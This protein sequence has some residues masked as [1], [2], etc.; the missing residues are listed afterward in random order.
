MKTLILAVLLAGSFPLIGRGASHDEPLAG[1]AEATPVAK[2]GMPAAEAPE[3]HGPLSLTRSARENRPTFQLPEMVITGQGEA[4]A[5]S[6]RGE[7]RLDDSSAGL[8]SSP[9]EEEGS[10]NESGEA[11]RS[12]DGASYLDRP[13]YGQVSGALGLPGAWA[14][15]LLYGRQEESWNVLAQ[16]RSHG[17]QTAPSGLFSGDGP[18]IQGWQDHGLGGHFGWESSASNRFDLDLEVDSR[19]QALRAPLA[20]SLARGLGR[21]EFSW[22]AVFEGLFRQTL[23]I[24]GAAA[25]LDSRDAAPAFG[26]REDRGTLKGRWES[27]VP[28]LPGRNTLSWGGEATLLGQQSYPGF[29]LTGGGRS[30]LWISGDLGGR[31]SIWPGASLGVAVTGQSWS[32]SS[33]VEASAWGLWPRLQ[34]DQRLNGQWSL[35]AAYEPSL[36]QPLFSGSLY[37]RD[38]GVPNPLL[39]PERE[40]LKASGGVRTHW[41]ETVALELSGFYRESERFRV[42][43]DPAALGVWS[44]TDAGRVRRLGLNFQEDSPLGPAASQFFNYRWQKAENLDTAAQ[45][46]FF[47]EHEARLGVKY[48]SHP[49]LTTASL[50]G[51]SARWARQSGGTSMEPALGLDLRE[52]YQWSEGFTIFAEGLNLLAQP[53]QEWEG[54]PEAR[55]YLGLGAIARF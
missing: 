49:W 14:F 31:F 13:A 6:Q 55:P 51:V 39:L 21:A 52:E 19:E 53:L 44:E 8:K 23:S 2:K 42:W 25:R 20:G 43:D 29:G 17:K 18:T 11:K 32:V 36:A 16:A 1:E 45:V 47:P 33:P 12:L 48:F 30:P 40:F 26:F 38:L 15:D 35:F 9:A 3:E 46:P 50:H 10:K 34:W 41:R 7:L 54:Y 22:G 28:G 27:G 5:I 4:K 37:S 24:E